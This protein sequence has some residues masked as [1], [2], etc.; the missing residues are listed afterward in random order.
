MWTYTTSERGTGH[1]PFTVAS[2]RFKSYIRRYTHKAAG[3]IELKKLQ[4]IT[5]TVNFHGVRLKPYIFIH[6]FLITLRWFDSQE[7]AK[8]KKKK[9]NR[10]PL[11]EVKRFHF[12]KF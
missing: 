4:Y 2:R 6:F 9:K 12:L 8:K 7:R 1:R 3:P 5:Q 11:S 10:L